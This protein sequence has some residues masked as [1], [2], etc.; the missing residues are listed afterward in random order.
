MLCILMMGQLEEIV[1]ALTSMRELWVCV[2]KVQFPCF[3]MPESYGE[4]LTEHLR[5]R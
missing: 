5:D 2:H 3:P 4:T 1:Y